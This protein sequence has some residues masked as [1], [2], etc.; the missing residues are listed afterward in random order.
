MNGNP[1]FRLLI[2]RQF[3]TESQK[4]IIKTATDSLETA[5]E[6]TG[7]LQLF[8]TIAVGLPLKALWLFMN[9]F[10]LIAYLH[11]ISFKPANLGFALD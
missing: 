8:L 4:E 5:A 1:E 3:V 2:P 11:H 7:T 10:Q 9:Q 6:T